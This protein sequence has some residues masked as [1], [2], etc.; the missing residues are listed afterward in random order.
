MGN[1]VGVG[2]R[3]SSKSA[4]VTIT[5]KMLVCKPSDALTVTSYKLSA[6]ESDGFSKSGGDRKASAPTS[7]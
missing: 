3:D 2:E 1:G 7:M 4:T 5:S 6:F